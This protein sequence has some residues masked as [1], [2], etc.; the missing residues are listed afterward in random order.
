VKKLTL[1]VSDAAVVDV[2]EQAA[3]YE[4]R[5]DL[6]LSRRWDR[7]VSAALVRISEFPLSGVLCRFKSKKLDKIRRM[8]VAG[9]PKHLIFYQIECDGIFV[10]RV[11]HGARDLESLFSES[12]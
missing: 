3:W 7:A 10:L 4:Q 9:F 5:V 2:L 11:I 12:E 8:P 1:T 6:K